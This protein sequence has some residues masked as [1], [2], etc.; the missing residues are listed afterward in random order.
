[1]NIKSNHKNSKKFNRRERFFALKQG[2]IALLI[3][4]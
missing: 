1:M 4:R 2:A 3:I